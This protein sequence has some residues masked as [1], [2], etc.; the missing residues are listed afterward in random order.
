MLHFKL[1]EAC[2][3]IL[4]SFNSFKLYPINYEL[5][6]ITYEPSTMNH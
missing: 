3:S 6:A 2:E 5:Q 1:I 4:V